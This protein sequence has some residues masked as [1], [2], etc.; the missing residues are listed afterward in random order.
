MG[1]KLVLALVAL[2][3]SLTATSA[4]AST[5]LRAQIVT[6]AHAYMEY[7]MIQYQS[8]SATVVA[9]SPRPLSQVLAAT[10]K[11][12]GWAVDYEDPPYRVSDLTSSSDPRFPSRTFK[13]PAGG[14]FHS[15]YSEPPHMWS[16]TDSEAA[17]LDKIVADYNESGNPGQFVVRPQSDGSYAVVGSEPGSSA[18]PILDTPISI[19]SGTRTLGDTLHLIAGAVSAATGVAVYAA[20]HPGMLYG[21]AQTQVTMGATGVPARNVL[22]QAFSQAHWKVAWDMRCAAPMPGCWLNLMIVRRALGTSFG[23]EK[24]IPVQ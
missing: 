15:T 18:L 20:P 23:T 3:L 2:F 6:Q 9:N 7:V 5:A 1:E 21:L 24:P 19:P 17:A 10:R 16:R 4:L 22:V 12:Y 14:A 8:G 13:V 11:E